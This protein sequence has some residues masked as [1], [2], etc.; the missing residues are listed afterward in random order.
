MPSLPYE[1][2]TSGD[3]AIAEIQALL[4]KFNCRTFGIMTDTTRG[5][6]MVQFR[7]KERNVSIEASWK[8]YA[9]AYLKCHPYN[10]SRMRITRAEYESRAL[11]QARISVC[12]I[13]RD[14]I[15][16][17]ITA[18]EVGLLSFEGVFLSHIL[19]PDGRRLIDRVHSDILALPT[20]S[21]A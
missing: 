12:S 4:A 21:P 9:A 10:P 14:W 20:S 16:G 13:L 8:G 11:A 19:L 1:N 15:K 7:W 17:Q 5:C 3:K 18:V 2:A 6:T